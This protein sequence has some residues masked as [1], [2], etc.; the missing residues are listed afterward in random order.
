M[1]LMGPMTILS[2]AA[3]IF[4]ILKPMGATGKNEKARLT[5]GGVSVFIREMLPILI[6]IFFIVALTG[7][8]GLLKSAGIHYKI[9][10]L[11]PILPGLILAIFWVCRVNRTPLSR[12]YFCIINK[13]NFLMMFLVISI[14]VFKGMMTETGAV[15]DIRNELLEFGIPVILMTVAMPFISGFILGIAVGFVGASFPLIIPL[16]P[17]SGMF[18]Y[19]AYA[20]FAYTFGYMGMMLSPVHLCFL[21][22]KDYFRA[23][24]AGTYKYLIRPAL[25]VMIAAV[26]LFLVTRL[27]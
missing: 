4:F 16:F 5:W 12:L 8:T 26:A 13:G 27:V 9:P 19:L 21:V 20:A 1:L 15:A 10:A 2:V 7:L 24:L 6:V 18:D 23:S 25:S 14:M 22:T 11:F 17:S 3:G